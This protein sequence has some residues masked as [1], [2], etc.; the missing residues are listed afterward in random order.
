MKTISLSPDIEE[1]VDALVSSGMFHS[2]QAAVEELIRI[3]LSSIRRGTPPG[4]PP[5]QIP[6]PEKPFIP[7][8]S[9][10]IYKI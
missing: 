4:Y 6:Q 3:G 7:D 2:F 9:R 5:E 1:E 10:D 8:P